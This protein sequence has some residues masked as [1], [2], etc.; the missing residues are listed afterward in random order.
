MFRLYETWVTP[1]AIKANLRQYRDIFNSLNIGFHHPK[2][3]Q[4][5]VC[6]SF[7]SI[8]AE[9]R[10]AAQIEEHQQHLSNRDVSRNMKNEVK[11]IAKT[12]KTHAAACFDFQKIL[13]CPT[14]EA[15]VLY[16]KRKLAVY[17]FTIFD[18]GSNVGTCFVWDES[19]AKRGSNEVGSCVM[20][21]MTEKASE[22]VKQVRVLKIVFLLFTLFFKQVTLFSDNCAGQNRNRY[23]FG[24]YAHFARKFGVSV[25]HIFL[26][27]G[28]TQNEADSVHAL[29]ERTKKNAKIYIP[30]QWYS[31][32]A[33]AKVNG[34][35][36]VVKEVDQSDIFDLK[37]FVN[38]TN[39]DKDDKNRKIAWSKVKEVRVQAE[40]PNIV[41]FKAN[42]LDPEYRQVV[43]YSTHQPSTRKRKSKPF[44]FDPELRTVYDRSLPIGEK[45]YKDLQDLCDAGVIPK[46]HHPFYKGLNRDEENEENDE[47]LIDK[48]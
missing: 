40:T 8:S 47:N 4:C 24:A 43:L 5:N 34:H 6:C 15:S 28:H 21:W 13:N 10:T 26:E 16:Y 23:I 11:A 31:L 25:A 27:P 14:G 29:I 42:L 41:Q 36:Y 7:E 37:Q 2:K 38:D 46:I 3:D 32:I 18:V 20:N 35:P 45:K 39:W 48:F 33:S 17:N 1:G 9:V 44:V 30:A 22:G 19:L 12:D